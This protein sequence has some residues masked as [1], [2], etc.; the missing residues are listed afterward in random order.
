MSLPLRPSVAAG[1]WVAISGQLGHDD[2]VLVTGGIGPQTR[3]ALEHFV[4]VLAEHGLTPSDVVKTN[5]FL[6]D[7]A[8]FAGMNEEYAKVFTQD[9]P[10]RSAVAVHQIPLG[11]IVEIEGWAYRRTGA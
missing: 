8:D 10:A 11:A 2:G 5:V 9:F 7:M 6:V 1:E 3:R 4:A